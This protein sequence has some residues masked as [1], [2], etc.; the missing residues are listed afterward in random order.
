[1]ATNYKSQ[2]QVSQLILAKGD[3]ADIKQDNLDGA[4]LVEFPDFEKSRFIIL[5][6]NEIRTQAG[7]TRSSHEVTI[8]TLTCFFTTQ[9]FSPIEPHMLQ[10][11]SFKVEETP[12][13]HKEII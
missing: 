13:F 8:H 11:I 3:T 9:I 2:L 6:N 10:L 7:G 4:S 1:M 5:S 12:D